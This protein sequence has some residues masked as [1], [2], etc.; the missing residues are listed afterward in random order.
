[1]S[2]APKNDQP[3][4]PGH[5]SSPDVPAN[6]P[7]DSHCGILDGDTAERVLRRIAHEA[8]E[9][10]HEGAELALVGIRTGGDY[11][12]QRLSEIIQKITG[13]APPLGLLDITL[14]R[15]DLDERTSQPELKQTHIPFDMAGKDVLL[16]DDVLFTGRTIRAALNAL[17]DFGRPDRVRLAVLVDRGHRELPIRPDIVGKNI[18]TERGDRVRVRFTDDHQ[19]ERVELYP[20]DSK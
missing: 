2:M 1:M 7:T 17:M 12:A 15:D 11:L 16:V 4:P 5:G 13:T 9:T 19:V 14:Y 18:P 20:S 10:R 8:L 3:V 6:P